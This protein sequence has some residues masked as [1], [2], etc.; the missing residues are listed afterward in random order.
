MATIFISYAHLDHVLA[1]RLADALKSLGHIVLWDID[2]ISAGDLIERR[3]SNL[4]ATSDYVVVLITEA[5]IKS[6]WIAREVQIAEQKERG[7]TGRFIIPF[8]FPGAAVPAHIGERLAIRVNDW[9]TF[10]ESVQQLNA[11]LCGRPL[12]ERIASGPYF[13]RVR[14]DP[15]SRIALFRELHEMLLHRESSLEWD[16][17]WPWDDDPELDKW[18]PEM[19][20]GIVAACRYVERCSQV[21]RWDPADDRMHLWLFTLLTFV[22]VGSLTKVVPAVYLPLNNTSLDMH[23]SANFEFGPPTRLRK[24]LIESCPPTDAID[25]ILGWKALVTWLHL[26]VSSDQEEQ[27]QRPLSDYLDRVR[28]F[29]WETIKRYETRFEPLTGKFWETVAGVLAAQV[30]ERLDSLRSEHP[31][32][33]EWFL[34]EMR[35]EK[36]ASIGCHDEYTSIQQQLIGLRCCYL[37]VGQLQP[38]GSLRLEVETLTEGGNSR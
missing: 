12:Y 31:E 19:F 34:H 27:R 24:E 28:E 15:A 37:Y 7:G 25:Y 29:S 8:A 3:I 22:Y 30:G 6:D 18:T 14:L 35:L 23:L 33:I 11:A 10:D 1:Q 38:D 21:I 5:A 4:I 2:R 36:Q 20:A 16:G 32:A 13:K 9:T 26:Q 17:W